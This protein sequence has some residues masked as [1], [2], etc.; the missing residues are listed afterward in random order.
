VARSL[1]ATGRR[2]AF[3]QG[4][5]GLKE[6][7]KHDDQRWARGIIVI[8]ALSEV[9]NYLDAPVAT[10]A[11]PTP[12]FG[13]LL[14]AR[15]SGLPVLIVSDANSVRAGR[16]LGSPTLNAARGITSASVGVVAMQKSTATQINFD[17]LG[18]PLPQ[19]EVY[20]RAELPVTIDT[21]SLP[22]GTKA[23]RLVLDVLVAPDGAGE[24]AVVSAFINERLV[25]SAVAATG[26]ATRL[27]F[28]L[29]DGLIGTTASVRAV[30]QRRSAQGDCRFEPQG[31]PAQILGSSAIV[32]ETADASPRDFSDLVA[33]WADSVEIHLPAAAA[34][35]PLAVLGLVADVLSALAPETV[36][37][38]VRLVAP[39]TTPSPAAPFISVSNE[40]PSGSTPRVRF[41]K[42]QVAVSNRAGH[43]L[44]DLGGFTGGAV[45]QLVNASGKA[46]LWIK[47]LAAD[48]TLPTPAE[49]RLDRGDVAF[50]DKTGVALALSTERDT[51]LRV[52]Y[53]EQVSWVTIADRFRTWIVGSLWALASIGFLFGLQ[54]MLRRRRVKAGD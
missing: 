7:A 26:E 40:P 41:D 17:R 14:A 53:P 35:R 46:G 2:V 25:D 44:L 6:L 48:G 38:S 23:S 12:A 54:R 30:V 20:G 37:L 39:G 15:I 52:S 42:G 32:I 50:L 8:G 31:Y 45:A 16:L 1:A 11:G 13:A 22:A 9:L 28:P 19:A 33:H 5:E 29:S 10:V 49:V 3:H 18:I 4:F 43:T 24:K 47:P 51:L 34:E 21:R 27:D 36:N